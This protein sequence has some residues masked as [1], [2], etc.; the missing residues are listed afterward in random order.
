M[1]AIPKIRVRDWVRVSRVKVKFRV[2]V[3]RSRDSI[4]RVMAS[5]VRFRISRVMF[6]GASEQWT[7]ITGFGHLALVLC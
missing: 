7:A 5:R 3:S 4:T 6:S 1:S 2:T